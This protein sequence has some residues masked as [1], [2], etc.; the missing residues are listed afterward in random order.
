MRY[1]IYGD[2]STTLTLTVRQFSKIED[3]L[4]DILYVNEFNYAQSI[5]KDFTPVEIEDAKSAAKSLEIF[6][7]DNA[8]YL[9][10]KNSKEF[11]YLEA[12]INSPAQTDIDVSDE[13]SKINLSYGS[14]INSINYILRIADLYA[15]ED[16]RREDLESNDWLPPDNFEFGTEDE[17]GIWKNHYRPTKKN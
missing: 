5:L 16:R 4:K 17:Q 15:L 13:F 6:L 12:I 11:D 7:G 1:L 8:D 10:C 14:N 3:I 2:V 9:R